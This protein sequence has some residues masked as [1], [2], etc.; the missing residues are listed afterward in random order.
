MEN[1]ESNLEASYT[2]EGSQELNGKDA[3]FRHSSIISEPRTVVKR[4]INGVL[5]PIGRL[6]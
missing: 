3:S 6:E 4:R 2:A 5:V 1:S